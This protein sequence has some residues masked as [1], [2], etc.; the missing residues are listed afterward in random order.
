MSSVASLRYLVSLLSLSCVLQGFTQ[1]AIFVI[2]V[3]ISPGVGGW[4][5]VMEQYSSFGEGAAGVPF[6]AVHMEERVQVRV[7]V[8]VGVEE[9]GDRNT[10]KDGTML[11]ATDKH[12]LTMIA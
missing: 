2:D 7:L 12:L 8:E 1:G 6:G 11:Q 5:F 10:E 9:L 3:A 4:F